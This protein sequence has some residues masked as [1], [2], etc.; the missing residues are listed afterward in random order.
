MRPIVINKK[1]VCKRTLAF[2]NDA[3]NTQCY[4][5]FVNVF[6][7]NHSV[8]LLLRYISLELPI[9][10]LKIKCMLSTSEQC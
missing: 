7:K 6:A 3:N 9:K 2:Y 10:H 1:Q 8:P 4:Y 5:M